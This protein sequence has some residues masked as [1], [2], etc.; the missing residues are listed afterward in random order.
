MMPKE[1]RGG[2][3][4]AEHLPIDLDAAVDAARRL[5]DQLGIIMGLL[6]VLRDTAPA[7]VYL[8]LVKKL[9]RAERALA[10]LAASLR[11]RQPCHGGDGVQ[12]GN[13]WQAHSNN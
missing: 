7:P 13:N 1:Q 4:Q 5:Q 11:H 9:E 10:I 6:K 8:A 2:S 12:D 3:G